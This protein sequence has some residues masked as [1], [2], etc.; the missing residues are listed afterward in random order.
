MALDRHDPS[1]DRIIKTLDNRVSI[2]E[3]R[4]SQVIDNRNLPFMITFSGLVPMGVESEPWKPGIPLEITLAVPQLALPPTTSDFTLDEK[5]NGTTFRTLTVPVGA[6]YIEDAVPF[7][8][9]AGSI[10]TVI[11][12]D[13]GATAHE[14]ALHLH[15]K[16]L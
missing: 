10:Y 6:F 16:L 4:L 3:R 15:P 8:I 7:I 2:L 5:L 12:T 1:V 14:L 11:C 13:N 9:P